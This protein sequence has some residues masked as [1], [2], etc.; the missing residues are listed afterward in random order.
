MESTKEAPVIEAFVR[1]FKERGL[2]FA[3]RSDNGLPFASP[4]GQYNLSKLSVFWLRLGI[5]VERIKHGHP[6]QHGSHERMH[7]TLKAETTKPAG[8]N[9]LQRQARFDAFISEFNTERPPEA[10]AMKTPAQIYQNSSK[11]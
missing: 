5:G 3:I 8:A 1:L 11:P 9:I 7:R 4:N 10:I 6:T 2:P